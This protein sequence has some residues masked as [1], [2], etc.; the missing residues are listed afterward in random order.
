[1]PSKV[2]LHTELSTIVPQIQGD[3]TKV[4]VS[5]CPDAVTIEKVRES[6][7]PVLTG[8]LYP[9][10]QSLDQRVTQPN[11]T[12]YRARML[13]LIAQILAQLNRISQAQKIQN[14]AN[15]TQYTEKNRE[16]AIL[17]RGLSQHNL[18]SSFAL[19]GVSL[20][21]MLPGANTLDQNVFNLLAKDVGPMIRDF[22]GSSKQIGAQQLLSEANLVLNQLQALANEG[23]LTKSQQDE[24]TRLL[25]ELDQ[26]LVTAARAG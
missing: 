7:K 17:N 3:A 4:P 1:M 16:A 25:Q 22:L 24:M 14:D 9:V 20:L 15:K 13:A 26:I 8:Q 6:G 18:V 10:S 21:P 19:F 11:A 12:S 5:E 2:D 23:Q